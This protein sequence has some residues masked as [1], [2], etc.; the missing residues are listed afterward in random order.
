MVEFTFGS[1]PIDQ[2]NGDQA[3]IESYRGIA[4]V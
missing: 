2:P 3:S 1:A 4:E